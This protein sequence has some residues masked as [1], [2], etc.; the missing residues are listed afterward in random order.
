[1]TPIRPRALLF[2]WDNTLIDSWGAIHNALAVTFRAMGREP[3]TFEQTRQR[4]RASARDAFPVL[5]GERAGE[6]AEIFY[7]A[8]E[9]EHLD[10][11]RERDGA[12]D[13]L[14]AL[15]AE[16][17]FYLAVV[18][19]KRGYLLRREAVHLGWSAYFD[20]LVGANDAVR[21]K[22]AAA[23]VELALAEAPVAPGPEVW[24]VGDTDIDMRCAVDA[25]CVPVLLRPAPPAEG[26]FGH[27][28]RLHVSSCGAL[29]EAL[30]AL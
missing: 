8:F 21:D 3:W 12:G 4:V 20:R 16:K 23:A 24:F 14:R 10:N 27:A 18:S 25:G 15:A 6:A 2:D 19:N 7:R 13:M 26:E 22:P 1:M 29:L 5:F 11:L 30:R 9:A 28:P 17:A